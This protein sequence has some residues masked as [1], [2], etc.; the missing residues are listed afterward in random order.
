MI[1]IE[2]YFNRTCFKKSKFCFMIADGGILFTSDS[3]EFAVRDSLN[4][5]EVTILVKT[6]FNEICSLNLNLLIMAID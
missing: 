6:S 2:E 5:V 1:Y 4:S 3:S